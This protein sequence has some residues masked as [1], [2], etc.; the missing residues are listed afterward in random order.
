L[1]V[2]SLQ[3]FCCVSNAGTVR[4]LARYLSEQHV[5]L[6]TQTTIQGAVTQLRATETDRHVAFVV[7]MACQGTQAILEEVSSVL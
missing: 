2:T 5:L 1:L 6:S 7:D 4:R 3:L